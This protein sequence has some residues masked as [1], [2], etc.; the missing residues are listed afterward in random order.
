MND[1]F[2]NSCD[3]LYS[4]TT[5]PAQ[6]L[7]FISVDELR[8]LS[9][10]STSSAIASKGGI[11]NWFH[12]AMVS[13]ITYGAKMYCVA[14]KENELAVEYN[15]ETTSEKSLIAVKSE[16]TSG[17][18]LSISS[19]N[20]DS[21]YN[22]DYLGGLVIAIL[23]AKGKEDML[24]D[25]FGAIKSTGPAGASSDEKVKRTKQYF[26]ICECVLDN[27]FELENEVMY[28]QN[29]TLKSLSADYIA[30]SDEFDNLTGVI[31]IQSFYNYDAE[32]ENFTLI[33][34]KSDF[35]I[36]TE[37][38][39]KMEEFDLTVTG[40][41]V[42][43][44][45]EQEMMANTAMRMSNYIPTKVGV[46]MAA[47]FYATHKCSY[48]NPLRT[49]MLY[50]PSGTGKTEL[51]QYLGYRLGLP[52]TTFSCTA[53]TDEQDLLG[54][55]ISLGI[56]NG[57]DGKISYTETELVKAIKNGWIIEIQEA[58]VVK[59]T[60]VHQL[61]NSLFDGTEL[62]Q[63]PDGST[64]TPHPD[65]IAVFTTNV[66]YEGCN[67]MNQ[68]LISRNQFVSEVKLPSTEETIERLKA[69]LSWPEDKS[70]EPI[71]QAVLC[72][73][74]IN[75]FLRDESLDDGSCDFR[76]VKDWLQMFLS[77]N[78]IGVKKSLLELADYCIIT[79]ATLESEYHDTI[80]S[81]IEAFVN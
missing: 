65:F 58:A 51:V 49:A 38:T 43:T 25:F 28:I 26:N 18:I 52:V 46:D 32:P 17:K 69:Q 50:G 71:S 59:E 78:Q 66:S 47:A 1:L 45:T 13:V 12:L 39:K 10:A 72:M 36:A 7:N 74:K 8:N 80:R 33:K 60:A 29:N 70:T 55:P 67:Q 54:K 77:F 81:L 3:K 40:T 15:S 37:F 63:L 14:K 53:N 27:L 11:P 5:Y 24:L 64:L 61:F 20:S 41:R 16:A 34:V 79:K 23:Y 56:A 21:D 57:S 30:N 44:E 22:L 2:F 6:S 19:L 35:D 62:V 68:S 76:A 31:V 73:Q 75:E 4:N 42:F 9:A 48:G